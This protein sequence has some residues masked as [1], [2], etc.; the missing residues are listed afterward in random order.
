MNT[1]YRLLGA[2]IGSGVRISLECDLAEYDLVDVGHGASVDFATLRGFGVDNGAMILGP[3][4]IGNHASVGAKS[5]VAPFT[6]IPDNCHLGPVTSSYETSRKAY[7]SKHARVNRKSLPEPDLCMKLFVEGPIT[8]LV[9]GFGQ[10]PSLLVLL[11]MLQYKGA[12]ET[13]S[14]LG[15]LMAWLCDPKRIPYYIGIRIARGLVSPF[16]YMAA[17]IF[18]KKLIIGKF[19]PGPRDTFDQWQLMRHELVATLFCRKRIQNVTDIIGRHYE[20]VSVLYRLLGA[21]VGKRV[22]WPGHQPI[23]TGEFDLLEIGDDVVFGSRSSIYFTTFSTCEK[24][25]LCAGSN[26]ADNCVVLPG[27]TLGK[28]SVLG[29][30]SVCPEGWYL[31]ESSLWLGSQGCEPICLEKG[32]EVEVNGHGLSSEVKFEKLPMIGDESTLRPFGKAFYHRKANYFVWPL[33]W[34]VIYSVFVKTFIVIFHTLPL[35]GSLHATAVLLYGWPVSSRNYHLSK[36][37]FHTIYCTTLAMY[38][39][40]HLLRV[41]LWLV[42]ELT[43]KWVF[44]GRRKEGVYNYDTCSYAQRWELYQLIAKIRSFSRLNL[45]QFLSGTP[46]MVAYFRLNGGDIGKDCCLYP[47]GADPFMPEPDLVHMGDRCVLDCA[48]VVCHLN[49][50]GA[51]TLKEINLEKDTTLRCRS[52]VQQAVHVEEGAQLLEKSL[53]MTG[54]VIEAYSV[55][56]DAPAAFWFQYDMDKEEQAYNETSRLLPSSSSRANSTGV[57]VT[58][59][60]VYGGREV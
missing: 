15:D 51:F 45:L 21:K 32:V 47:A 6:S 24:V 54:E 29:S 22:F 46:Y 33:S 50:R 53:A 14:N 42:I 8:F 48:S 18:V 16:F 57:S 56:K 44:M 19:E 27:S 11:R 5:V 10:I 35:L 9:N 4:K 43:A 28:N 13:F 17:A 23:T 38:V 36:Y 34:I 2:K 25:I 55:W 12:H 7:R 59:V 58:D 31:P 40:T 60:V 41:I 52:R 26:V 3:V 30:N 49:T 37:P 1:Y 20:L 39:W